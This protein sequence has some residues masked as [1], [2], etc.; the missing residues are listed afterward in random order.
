MICR[1]S[2]SSCHLLYHSGF[3]LSILRYQQYLPVVTKPRFASLSWEGYRPKK[4]CTDLRRKDTDLRRKDTDL[5]KENT[6]LKK[7][8]IAPRKEDT[9]L[10]KEDTDLRALD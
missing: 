6:D 2:V 9:D 4:N 3:V 1:A 7:E 10:K 8:D 5:R